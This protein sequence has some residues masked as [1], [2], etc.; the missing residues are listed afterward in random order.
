MWAFLFYRFAKT[1]DTDSFIA[2]MLKWLITGSILE[3]LVAVPCHVIVRHK[4]VC[5]AQGLTFYGIAAGLAVMA[6][7][8]G[9]GI[10]FLILKRARGLKPSADNVE[11]AGNK[12]ILPANIFTPAKM[13]IVVILMVCFIYMVSVLE[14]FNDELQKVS[15]NQLELKNSL[16]NKQRQ[17]SE[18]PVKTEEILVGKPFPELQFKAVDGNDISI[19]QLKGKF[20]LIV[21]WA[22]WCGPC[23]SEIPGLIEMYKQY[24]DKGFEIIGISLDHDLNTFKEFLRSNEIKW[25][26]YFDGKGWNNKISSRFGINSIPSTVLIDKDGIV[27]K[28]CLRG[29]ELKIAIEKL[30]NPDSKEFLEQ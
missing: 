18:K 15:Q 13:A 16:E 21:F 10:A 7:A 20:V 29:K 12:S 28:R 2:R 24:H 22:T 1:T 19:G 3:L 27:L 17:I 5:C 9:P 26:Q 11:Q 6:L 14:K 30:F 25:P 4:D 23:K 8:F